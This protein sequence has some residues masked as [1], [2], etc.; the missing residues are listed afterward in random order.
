MSV[1]P[2]NETLSGYIHLV[3][4]RAKALFQDAEDS[5]VR[6]PEFIQTALEELRLALEELRV[7]E[8]EVRCQNEELFATQ[9]TLADERQRY[10]ELFDFAPDGYVIT[11]LHATIREANC[12]VAKLL[13]IEQRHLYGKPL[14]SFIAENHLRTFRTLL[15]HLP[16]LKRIE[17]W[18]IQICPGQ[19]DV[20]DAALTAE[21]VRD[22]AGNPVS[23]RWMVRDITLR[24]KTEAQLQE[25]HLQ[26][27]ELLEANRAKNQFISTLSHEL[28]TPLTAVIGFSELLMRRLRVYQESQLMKMAESIFRNG[29]HLLILV[30]EMLD[31]AKLQS[32]R[33]QLHPSI[34]DLNDL[35]R[36]TVNEMRS[37]AEQK[38]LHIEFRVPEKPV[39]IKSDCHRLRQVLIN[40]LSNAIKFTQRGSVTVEVKELPGE[41]VELLVRDTGIG[42]DPSHQARIFNEFWQV[43][44]TTTRSYSGTGLGLAITK[45]LVDLMQG[46][47]SVNSQLGKGTVFSIVLP[48]AFSESSPKV[49]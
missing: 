41:K 34:L 47:I 7:A 6:S 19:G 27:L 8:E 16:G 38:G 3:D 31:F 17:E 13:N 32:N 35:G 12:A 46:T 44:Q 29:K 9:Q 5:H 33:L 20:F 15:N 45:S 24:K 11:D 10:Q 37:L 39:I 1:S 26:N 28:R 18:E 48:R 2:E 43:N 40:L 22:L 21:V 14:S 30:E 49:V 25:A 36:A 4:E 23:F 42:I